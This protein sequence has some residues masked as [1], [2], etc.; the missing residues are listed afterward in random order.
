[1]A[2]YSSVGKDPIGKI[3]S[4]DDGEVE[5]LEVEDEEGYESEEGTTVVDTEDG[6]LLVDFDPS[7]GEVDPS[8]FGANLAES[9][10]DQDLA[11]LGSDLISEYNNDKLSRKDWEKTYEDGLE[12]LGLSIER[13]S[14]PFDGAS[15]VTHPILSEAVVRFQSQAIGEVFPSGGPVKT[16]VI[17]KFG[18]D[19]IAHSS[20]VSNYMNYLVEEEIPD[21]REDKDKL[22]FALPGAGS[23]FTKIFL[24]PASNKIQSTFIPAEDIVVNYGAKSLKSASRVTE[25][26]RES[27][28]WIAKRK[29]AGFYRDVELSSADSERT[30]LKQRLLET[31]GETAAGYNDDLYTLIECHCYLDLSEYDGSDEENDSGVADPYVVTIDLGSSKILS[32]YRNWREEDPDREK[33]HHYTHYQYIPGFGFYGLGLIHLIGGI[34]KGSTSMLRQLIDAGTFSNL[35]AGFKTR[36]MR[37]KGDQ[38]PLAPGQF[39]DVDVP[40]GKISDNVMALPYKEPSQTLF[41]LLMALIEDGR[42]FA[43]LTDINVSNMSQESP[44][45]TTLALIERNMK[46]MSS[47]L[48]RIH[49]SLKDEYSIIVGI[50]KDMPDKV[51]PYEVDG[52]SEQMQA[53]FDSRIDII[54]VSD[55]NSST[56]AHRIMKAQAAVQM[57]NMAPTLFNGK[58]LFRYAM[59]VMEIPAAKDIIPIEDDIKPMDP[60]TENMSILKMTPVK[61]FIEQD[62]QA[63]I[64]VHMLGMQDPKVQSILSQ[65]PTAQASAS[66]M[67][68]HVTEHV[69]YQ[70][71]MEMQDAL[72]TQLPSEGQP[73]PPELEGEYSRLVAQA[74]KKLFSRNTAEKQ[75][76]E[77]EEKANDPLTEIRMRELDIEETESRERI[78]RDKERLTL[79]KAKLMQKDDSQTADREA[80]TASDSERA[81]AQIISNVVRAASETEKLTSA[82]RVKLFESLIKS[83]AD[84]A[85]SI[86]VSRKG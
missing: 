44:V 24:D 27:G 71:R 70:Y 82:E 55:P 78:S 21:Y 29:R 51:Y 63:H 36:G 9:M 32:I 18:P 80:K 11:G 45:G 40:S 13:R 50:L 14:E 31:T 67:M 16:K 53:D 52:G 17:G 7:D 48:T 28:N 56:S 10:S 34:A 22:L 69:A 26:I 49:K 85:K 62:H 35:P 23:A 19:S 81:Q 4:F 25:I 1:V 42:R 39:R 76:L 86:S 79:E 12:L 83:V 57:Y 2:T 65:S 38:T 6:G 72:G 54:P 61:A 3:P 60:I 68:A 37:I 58:L 66:A 73:L 20:R 59:D 15:G 33:R 74:A 41:Q 47:I 46:V 5:F 64:Q 84:E 77:N 30:P 75:E 43:S 8:E